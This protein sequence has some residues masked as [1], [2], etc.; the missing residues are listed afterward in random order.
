MTVIATD[1]KTIAADSLGLHGWERSAM[2]A[3][4]IITQHGKVFAVSGTSSSF[5][6]LVEWYKK[7]HPIADL[8]KGDWTFIVFSGVGKAVRFTNEV[9]YPTEIGFPFCDGSGGNYALG[10]M[11]HPTHPATPE[12]AVETAIKISIGCGGPIQV[13]DITT[14]TQQLHIVEAAE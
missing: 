4:K 10:A 14:A 2:P 13:V 7:G 9:G 8:P 11:H 1:G 5:G 6:P 3:T 12:Q